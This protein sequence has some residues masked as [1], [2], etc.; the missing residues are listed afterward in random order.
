MTG[1]SR[2]IALAWRKREQVAGKP[3]DSGIYILCGTL[4]DSR[5]TSRVVSQDALCVPHQDVRVFPASARR[6]GTERVRSHVDR[7]SG[8]ESG[9]KAGVLESWSPGDWGKA[10]VAYPGFEGFS[11]PGMRALVQKGMDIGSGLQALASGKLG[12]ERMAKGGSLKRLLRSLRL[13]GK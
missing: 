3:A 12:K 10:E 8:V 6:G 4:D 11:V 1:E 2:G 9:G 5:I 13:F 7:V